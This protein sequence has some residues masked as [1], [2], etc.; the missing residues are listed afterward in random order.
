MPITAWK[1]ASLTTIPYD[2]DAGEFITYGHGCVL[3]VYND[4]VQI[5]SDVYGT[6]LFAKWWNETTQQVET[7][8]L[9]TWEWSRKD[10]KKWGGAHA[11]VDATEEVWAKVLA[12][13]YGREYQKTMAV[14]NNEAAVM[15]KGD[16]VKIVRGRAKDANGRS[17]LGTVGKVVV[18]IIKPYGMGYHSPMEHKFAVATSDVMV[19]Y[20]APNGKVYK[21]HQDQVWVWS[22]NC[23]LVQPKAIDLKE[24]EETSMRHAE[25]ELNLLKRKQ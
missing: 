1:S 2:P 8:C 25:Y 22:R 3:A 20:A 13:L 6:G 4:S 23:E 15:R 19:D 12:F 24:V 9:D 18:D 7:V 10:D 5:M 16:T 14:R 11:E 21:N 17:A